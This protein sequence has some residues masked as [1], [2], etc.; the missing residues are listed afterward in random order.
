VEENT[1]AG[2][3]EHLSN[4]QTWLRLLYMI[5]FG[6]VFQI[7]SLV[8]GLVAVV[9]IL[10]KLFSGEAQDPLR[11]LGG[12]LAAYLREI[13]E[14]LTF[15]SDARP[16]PWGPSPTASRTSGGEAPAAKAAGRR[17]IRAQGKAGGEAAAG[18]VKPE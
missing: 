8:A 6:I 12:R 9:Q 18:E 11:E 14:F 3:R 17:R 15:H 5:L 13:V 1:S 16:Y 7:A 4:R 2:I 10:F